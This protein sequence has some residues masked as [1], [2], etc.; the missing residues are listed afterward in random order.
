MGW[1][2]PEAL[3]QPFGRHVLMTCEGRATGFEQS[4]VV[5]CRPSD[6]FAEPHY[7]AVQV[8]ELA[9][10]SALEALQR[11]RAIG[12]VRWEIAGQP[13]AEHEIAERH[14]K[15]GHESKGAC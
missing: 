14:W 6:S 12:A 7:F 1:S 15:R 2:K 11:R 4:G 13:A 5:W 10:R 3:E 8:F 9:A